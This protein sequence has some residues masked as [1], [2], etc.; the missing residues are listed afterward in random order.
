MCVMLHCWS[1]CPLLQAMDGCIPCHGTTS[2]YQS[3]AT[4]KIVK[5]CCSRVLPY[6]QR[7]QRLP[8]R[9]SVTYSTYLRVPHSISMGVSGR[10]QVCEDSSDLVPVVCYHLCPLLPVCEVLPSF[11]LAAVLLAAPKRSRRY[12]ENQCCRRAY[13]AR[14]SAWRWCV[15]CERRQCS[16]LQVDCQCGSP[17]H[18]GHRPCRQEQCRSTAV[19]LM[20]C[21][22]PCLETY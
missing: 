12:C 6:K 11:T 2:S 22:E 20:T 16:V 9:L 21:I 8:L 18:T 3:A 5:H 15:A 7:K 10:G 17:H 14:F 4:S 13:R 1:T 19:D